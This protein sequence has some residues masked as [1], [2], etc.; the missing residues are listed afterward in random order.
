M[1][2]QLAIYFIWQLPSLIVVGVFLVLFLRKKASRPAFLRPE[3]I[4]CVFLLLN[5]FVISTIL[6]YWWLSRAY[7][8]EDLHNNPFGYTA[9]V[10]FNWA[11]YLAGQIL[12][13]VAFGLLARKQ[14]STASQSASEPAA[15]TFMPYQ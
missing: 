11:V 4:A 5:S 7:G 2:Q 14:K 8:D 6:Q 13:I 9:L 12:L 10:I 3:V 1:I 15:G